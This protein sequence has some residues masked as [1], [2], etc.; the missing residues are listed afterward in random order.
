MIKK[1]NNGLKIT[2]FGGLDLPSQ[3]SEFFDSKS[4]K[5]VR[6]VVSINK[7]SLGV[8]QHSKGTLG[9]DACCILEILAEVANEWV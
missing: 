6:S 2:H 9:S 5:L 3:I 1:Y 7:L 8:S 4:N